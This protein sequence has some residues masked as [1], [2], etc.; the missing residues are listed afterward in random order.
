MKKKKDKFRVS[1]LKRLENTLNYYD[2]QYDY[3]LIPTLI[4]VCSLLAIGC[5]I[6]AFLV[7]GK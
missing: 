4:V 7:L 5:F 6:L 2:V 1:W 3:K